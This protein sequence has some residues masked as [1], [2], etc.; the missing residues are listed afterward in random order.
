[1]GFRSFPMESVVTRRIIAPL[2]A[3]TA[4]MDVRKSPPPA[5]EP[6]RLLGEQLIEPNRHQV[7]FACMV[8]YDPKATAWNNCDQVSTRIAA[9][10]KAGFVTDTA[11]RV[12][13]GGDRKRRDITFKR[14][15]QP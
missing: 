11:L 5:E 10:K 12:I 13:A 3:S 8:R 6:A 7:R 15:K 4:S 1:M 14:A 9:N 2:V